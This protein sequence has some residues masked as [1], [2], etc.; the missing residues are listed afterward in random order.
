MLEDNVKKLKNPLLPNYNKVPLK[1]FQTWFTKKL[2]SDMKK[3]VNS[4][5]ETNHEFEHFLFDD[6]D[7]YTFIKN[8]Y[9]KYILDAFEKLIPGAYKADLWRY[10]VLYFYGGIYIDIKFSHKNN[11]KF[12]NLID[13]E[14]FV[15]DLEFSG[16]GV[17]NGLIIVKQRNEKLLKCIN[18]IVINTQNNYYGETFLHITGPKLFDTFFTDEEK[19]ELSLTLSVPKDLQLQSIK[20]KKTKSIIL[21]EYPLYREEQNKFSNKK[22]Y[23]ILWKERNI[24]KKV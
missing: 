8:N 18:E 19:K 21:M 15:N 7:C 16:F 2:P 17:Y 1:I 5:K 24:Y 23:A 3:A 4:I 9:S 13:K 10:C 12:I 11:F 6:D 14:Y 22:H 20:D